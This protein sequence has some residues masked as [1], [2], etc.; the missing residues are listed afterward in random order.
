MVLFPALEVQGLHGGTVADQSA[1]IISFTKTLLLKL[2]MVLPSFVMQGVTERERDAQHFNP[3]L[4]WPNALE[5][6]R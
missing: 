1:P 2:Q 4:S 3:E 6:P 5:M